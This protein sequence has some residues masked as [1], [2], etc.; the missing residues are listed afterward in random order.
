MACKRKLLV[1]KSVPAYFAPIFRR[2][3][4]NSQITSFGDVCTH[5]DDAADGGCFLPSWERARTRLQEELEELR[6]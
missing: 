1:R 2:Q 3:A 5:R 6:R 4:P